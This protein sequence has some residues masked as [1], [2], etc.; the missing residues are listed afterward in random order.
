MR[1]FQ[2]K[3]VAA[4]LLTGL[5][6][7]GAVGQ[8]EKDSAG[9][10]LR[11][12]REARATWDGSFP[13]FEAEILVR[14]DESA[15]V[16]GKLRVAADGS[17]ELDLPEGEAKDWAQQQLRSEV[18]HRIDR[19]SPFSDDAEYASEEDADHP[20]GRLIRLSG[21]RFESSY[22]IKGNEML[23]VNRT[24][25]DSRFSNKVLLT[26]ENEEGKS[27]PKV[28]TLTYWDTKT[29]ALQRVETFSV[30]WSRQGRYDLPATRVQ[31]V[32]T[33]DSAAVHALELSNH[34]LLD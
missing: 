33:N 11:Q 30:T 22:R 17:L 31:V 19:P 32:S 8:E 29:G 25:G 12:A 14:L 24:M 6:W 3:S 1:G 16:S 10:M 34:R 4:F 18:M 28:F 21:D 7:S 27:L 20:L 23:E 15:P 2:L 13:G 5:V 26:E 9:E